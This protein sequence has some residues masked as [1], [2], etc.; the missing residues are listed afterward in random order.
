MIVS[1]STMYVLSCVLDKEEMFQRVRG[2]KGFMGQHVCT[3][4]VPCGHCGNFEL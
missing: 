1:V 2:N 3:L 4:T